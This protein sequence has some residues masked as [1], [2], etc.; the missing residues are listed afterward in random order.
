MLTIRKF[1]GEEK[2]VGS[3]KEKVIPIGGINDT[4]NKSN[5]L[6]VDLPNY[7]STIS[8]IPATTQ[9]AQIDTTISTIISIPAQTIDSSTSSVISKETQ[10]IDSSTISIIAQ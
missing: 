8:A 2:I 9:L 10:T 6:G 3:P 1:K 7:D 4:S 5:I